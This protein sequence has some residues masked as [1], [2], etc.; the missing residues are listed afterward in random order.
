MN[1]SKQTNKPIFNRE[2][3]DFIHDLQT[4]NDALQQEQKRLQGK[5]KAASLTVKKLK[6]QIQTLKRRSNH[7]NGGYGARSNLGNSHGGASDGSI[8]R[9][10]RFSTRGSHT[11]VS[12][13]CRT[14]I[15]DDVTYSYDDVDAEHVLGEL[16]RRLIDADD[17][18]RRLK[19]E[20]RRLVSDATSSQAKV[21]NINEDGRRICTASTF[22]R[23]RDGRIDLSTARRGHG[24]MH[25][26]QHGG[27]MTKRTSPLETSEV[28]N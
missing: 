12:T 5:L 22:E 10:S 26:L 16:Q 28:S 8:Q 18:I 7:K 13:G 11:G 17:E 14:S 24:D 6:Q 25:M 23:S 15:D 2:E 9:S 1:K 19:D 3:K 20:N 27:I 4:R 21:G